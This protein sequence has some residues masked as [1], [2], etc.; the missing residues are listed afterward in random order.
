MSEEEKA[1]L[2][3]EAKAKA[4]FDKWADER[5]A[6]RAKAEAERKAAEEAQKKKDEEDEF[7]VMGL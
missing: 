4:L 7:S 5:D 2:E 1:R 3:R 6:A